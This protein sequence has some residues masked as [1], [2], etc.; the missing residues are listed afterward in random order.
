MKKIWSILFMAVCFALVSCGDD[1][2]D[3]QNPIEI[4]GEW[5]LQAMDIG[6]LNTTD[7]DIEEIAEELF[8][9]LS[10]EYYF[11]DTVEFYDDG[12]ADY[13][14]VTV[15]YSVRK[16]VITMIDDENYKMEFS[17]TISGSRLILTLD[18]RKMLIEQMEDEFDKEEM[19]YLK[20]SLKEF[21]IEFTYKR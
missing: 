13:H 19:D 4:L 9:E 17:Y 2:N 3:T 14:G 1:D 16:S 8:T 7:L 11:G 5:S 6:S 20:K 15:D 12:T 10:K 18:I 21:T